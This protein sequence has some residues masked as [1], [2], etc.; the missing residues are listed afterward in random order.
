MRY[1]STSE[2]DKDV[3]MACSSA[4]KAIERLIIR[5]L[6]KNDYGNGVNEIAYIATILSADTRIVL[7]YPE[8]R[9]FTKKDK[10]FEF[11]LA[12]DH[13]TFLQ[14]DKA[15]RQKMM[16]LSVLDA[17]QWAT[18]RKIKDFDGLRLHADVE[19]AFQGQ[20]WI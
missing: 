11:R 12:L 14:A 4:R 16:C 8:R 18:G 7:D 10:A 15:T 3:C 17:L 19:R 1:W 6:S 9:R 5:L 13:V 2:T 20:G